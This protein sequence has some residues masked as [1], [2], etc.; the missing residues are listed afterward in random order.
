MAPPKKKKP[1]NEPED[2]VAST[3]SEVNKKLTELSNDLIR[4]HQELQSI[5]PT[6]IEKLGTFLRATRE[7]QKVTLHTLA[8]L[9]G[10]SVG[11]IAAIEKGKL[12][13]SVE[14]LI[15]V[16]SALGKSLCIR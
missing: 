11:T 4:R 6:P 14:N 3:L 9:S 1:K 12:S 10:V 15:K 8:S 7:N 5:E 16:L 2:K 13:V